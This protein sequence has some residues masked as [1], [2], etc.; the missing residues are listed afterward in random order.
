MIGYH[1]TALSNVPSIL[2]T[3][4]H[5]ER[6]RADQVASMR[7]L[8]I[9]ERRWDGRGL[10]LWKVKPVAASHAGS[11]M[12]AA[13]KRGESRVALLRVAI[14]PGTEL[15]HPDPT[16]TL[17]LTHVGKLGEWQYHKAE[18]AWIVTE[19]IPAKLVQVVETYDLVEALAH[20]RPYEPEPFRLTPEFFPALFAQPLN[21][22]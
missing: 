16:S 1:Y 3:G 2:S 21:G 13:F 8:G 19:P 12:F 5:I 22:P 7:E 11:I 14:A 6:C 10:W 20:G 9:D 15:R 17:S 18:P 4:L